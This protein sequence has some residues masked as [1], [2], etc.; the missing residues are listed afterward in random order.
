MTKAKLDKH[1]IATAAGDITVF[2][3]NGDTREYFSSSVE[4]LAVGV[5]IPAHSCVDVPGESKE[6]YA[7]C[8]SQDLLGWEYVADHRGKTIYSIE[9]GEAR[10]ITVPGDYPPDTTTNAPVT[11]FD[12]WDGKQWV[13]DNLALKTDYIRRAEQQ[14]L[15]LQRQADFAIA[16]LQYAVDLEMATDGERAVLTAWKKY[17]VLLNRVDCSIAPDIDWPKVPE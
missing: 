17:C 8:R 9:T 4:F 16:P 10:V 6:G 11:L 13:T 12:K 3:Y 1:L 15:S 5:G 14:K 7:I 2:N